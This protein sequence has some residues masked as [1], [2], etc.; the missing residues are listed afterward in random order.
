M[1]KARVCI[2]I[3]AYNLHDM[4]KRC[5][6]KLIDNSDIEYDILVVDD[7]SATPFRDGRI[8]VLRLE[9][10]VGWTKANNAGILRCGDEYDYLCLLNN[11]TEPTKDFIRTIVD[12]MDK[13]PKIGIASPVRLDYENNAL[14]F[15]E[16]FPSDLIRGTHVVSEKGTAIADICYR[17]DNTNLQN[18]I[19]DVIWLPGVSLVVSTKVIRQVGLFDERMRQYCSDNEYCIRMHQRGYRVVLVTNSEV[20][21]HVG[22]SSKN[23]TP[24]K[25]QEALMSIV[26]C[27][28]NRKLFDDYPIDSKKNVWGR[29]KFDVYLGQPKP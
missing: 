7:G 21:H 1:L 15:R 3:P 18:N 9:E 23:L 29:L 27:S 12:E 25:D 24:Q 28:T 5:V 4:T 13:D 6:N 11:D 20:I 17:R 26:S 16:F 22:S 2:I 10:N 19:L 8:D 14:K